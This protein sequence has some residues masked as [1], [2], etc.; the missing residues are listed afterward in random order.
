MKKFAFIPFIFALSIILA[1]CSG[2]GGSAPPPANFTAVAGDSSVTVSWDMA[3]GVE[4]WL[5]FAPASGV[6]PDSCTSIPG[7]QII[8]NA[9][10]P[11]VVYAPTSGGAANFTT[12]GSLTGLTNGVTYSFTVNGRTNG[13]PGG[14]PSPA[15]SATPRLAGT[16]WTVGSSPIANDW[17]GV[18]SGTALV[19]GVAANVFVAVGANGSII[20]SSDGNN[21]LSPTVQVPVTANLNA[22]TS[23]G[24]TFL[25]VG[26]G[27]VVLSSSDAATWVQQTS[28]I[29]DNLNAVASNGAGG[30]VAVGD[31]GRIIVSGNG[32]S[33]S[34]VTSG[35]Q[36]NLYA[37]T[38]AAGTYVATGGQGTLLTST[39]GGVTWV[40]RTSGATADLKGIAYG[41]AT[42]TNGITSGVNTFVA[43]GASGTVVTSIDG[44]VTWQVQPAIAGQNLNAV[45][46]GHQ[47]VAVGAGGGIYTSVDGMNW[48]AQ[49]SGTTNALYAI[50][51][52]R[53]DYVSVGAAGVNLHS[54]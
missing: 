9:V 34:V 10:S 52:G 24:T 44:G 50:R 42:T 26:S 43:I 12:N 8:P 39:D 5:F 49:S 45:T 4:Y 31:A 33:W 28:G 21:W 15:V 17:Y 40:A 23:Y 14:T 53:F 19:S 51:G 2:E 36:N 3:P 35:T 48:Q 32:S 30:Y 22:I 7:C 13:G 27:G 54:I 1:A 16:I 25:A 38:Y 46:Y 20:S 6:T 11:M 29:A 41:G 18:A 47:F 37:V